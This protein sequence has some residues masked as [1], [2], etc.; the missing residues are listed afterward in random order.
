MTFV[1]HDTVPI[2]CVYDAH[3]G[4]VRSVSGDHDFES[5]L[6]GSLDS[7]FFLR[8]RA[9]IHIDLPPA[10]SLKLR[11][12]VVHQTTRTYDQ[13]ARVPVVVIRSSHLPHS[14][15]ISFIAGLTEGCR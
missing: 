12:P 7:R 8:Y 15:G 4:P 1:G 14:L 13:N 10:P 9:M 11:T 3:V 5:S 2:D 6:A